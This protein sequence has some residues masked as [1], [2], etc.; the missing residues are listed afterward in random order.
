M[1]ETVP[2]SVLPLNTKQISLCK[3][4]ESFTLEKSPHVNMDEY[5]PERDLVSEKIT[6]VA[7]CQR[8]R[9]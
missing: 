8:L 7:H 6:R 5:A 2:P 9:L 4:I 1:D 3:N